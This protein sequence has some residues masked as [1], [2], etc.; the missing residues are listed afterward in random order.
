M[1][2]VAP[3]V[4]R[5]PQD[6]TAL[7]GSDVTFEC[8]T[9]GDPA[10]LVTWRMQGGALPAGRTRL[11]DNRS[12]LRIERVSASDS[13]RYVCHVENSVGTATAS[14]L[15]TVLVPPTW[16]WSSNSVGMGQAASPPLS[17]EVRAYPTQTVSLDC[18]VQGTPKPLVFWS[19]EGAK[20]LM[21]ASPHSP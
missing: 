13:G 7:V 15:L 17:K 4:S 16:D 11:T 6:V 1:L 18:P 2:T 21:M 14:A 3:A 19:R 8:G 12:G 9:T 10:P 5:P 20:D